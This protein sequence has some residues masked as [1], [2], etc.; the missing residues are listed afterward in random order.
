M[1]DPIRSYIRFSGASRHVIKGWWWVLPFAWFVG[2]SRCWP[3]NGVR[4]LKRRQV[5]VRLHSGSRFLCY[6]EEVFTI[7][8]VIA[9]GEYGSIQGPINTIV[10]IGANI[11]VSTIWLAQQYPEATIWSFEPAPSTF[12]RLKVN[13]GL[14][15]IESRVHVIEA[16]AAGVAGRG[17]FTIGATSGISSL[18]NGKSPGISVNLVTLSAILDMVNSQIDLI[19]IDC[20][21]GEYDFFEGASQDGLKAV[22][23]IVGEAH[24][25]GSERHGS[26]ISKLNEAGF[27]VKES[28]VHGPYEIFEAHQI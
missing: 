11:G 4:F 5:Q 13:V 18:S 26:M 3:K 17:R 14:N 21:G 12:S 1:N 10:D 23:H 20:E 8:E 16:A 22:R 27:A 2:P 9:L 24:D 6:Y 15:G 19:K 28:N 7:M 25:V